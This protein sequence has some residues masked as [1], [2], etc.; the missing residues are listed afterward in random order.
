MKKF[1]FLFILATLASCKKEISQEE[2]MYYKEDNTPID[3]TVI[4]SVVGQASFDAINSKIENAKK[5]TVIVK[6]KDSAKT[7]EQKIADTKK[8]LEEANK[9]SKQD[10][11]LAKEKEKLQQQKKVDELIQQTPEN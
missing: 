5:D 10:E 6:K 8:K 9:K 3:T 4:D 2:A 7:T 11:K 1:L